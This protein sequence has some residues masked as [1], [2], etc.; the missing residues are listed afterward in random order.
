MPGMNVEFPS[1]SGVAPGYLATPASGS[2]PALVVVQEWW[3]LQP[4]IKQICDRYA[5]EGFFALAPDL[6]RGE[7]TDQPSEAEQKLM[8]FNIERAEQDL[9]GAVDFVAERAGVD[10]V[11]ST[12]YCIGGALCLFAA[13]LNPKVA[14]TASFYYVFPHKKPDFSRIE[15]PVLMHFGT[16]DD[17]ISVDA[18]K[19]LVDEV[20]A[21]G[22]DVSAE[23]YEGV[24]HA[25]CNT[26]NRLGTYDSEAAE[27]A[28]SRTIEFFR[29]NLS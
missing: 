17:F 7:T 16:A 4:E 14:A 21:A 19:A 6:Y 5:A 25:F 12:G 8:A 28:W 1:N 29:K 11:G 13:S 22:V 27:L 15:G 3:G 23:F 2:G 9:R 20:A 10:E 26:A 24:G 18:A